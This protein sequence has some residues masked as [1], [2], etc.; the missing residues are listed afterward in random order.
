MILASAKP[1]SKAPMASGGSRVLPHKLVEKWE[2][3]WAL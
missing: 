1:K 3:K 2:G